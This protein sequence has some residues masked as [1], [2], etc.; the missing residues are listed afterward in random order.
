LPRLLRTRLVKLLSIAYGKWLTGLSIVCLFGVLKYAMHSSRQ[1]LPLFVDLLSRLLLPLS[2]PGPECRLPSIAK[3]TRLLCFVFQ[4]FACAYKSLL[5][6]VLHTCPGNC[7]DIVVVF[8]QLVV[9]AQLMYCCCCCC[10]SAFTFCL[11]SSLVS[12][13]PLNHAPS[14][15]S[16]LCFLFN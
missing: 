11:I 6:F 2:A 7:S 9:T 8:V 12:H 14:S 10:G 13:C 4:S 16:H 5:L 3:V 1:L 15:F